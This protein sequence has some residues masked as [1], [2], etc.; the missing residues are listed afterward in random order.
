MRGFTPHVS[1]IG[2]VG[3]LPW[4]PTVRNLA[5]GGVALRPLVI[6]PLPSA[7]VQAYHSIYWIN[8]ILCQSYLVK[9]HKD[10]CLLQIRQSNINQNSKEDSILGEGEWSENLSQLQ[11]RSVVRDS[12]AQE[13]GGSFGTW[14]RT[15]AFVPQ[16]VP[17]A[18]DAS[19]F[20]RYYADEYMD[21]TISAPSGATKLFEI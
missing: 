6:N 17:V 11:L 7:S 16:M 18:S 15:S 14:F 4:E 20:T 5:S 21:D 12:W 13:C 19:L 10:S 9:V 1:L 3:Y 8:P 2:T